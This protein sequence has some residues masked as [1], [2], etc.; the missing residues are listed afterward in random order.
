VQVEGAPVEWGRKVLD[1]SIG[2]ADDRACW[3]AVRTKLKEEDRADHNLRSWHVPTFAPKLKQ[4]RTSGYAS[5]CV[6]KPLFSRY[7]FAR[8]DITRQL[9]DINYTRGVQSV[10]SFGGSAVSIDDSVI[11]LLRAQVGA[12]GFVRMEDEFK[13]GDKVRVTSGPFQ[14]LGGIFMRKLN[15]ADRVKILLNAMQFQG[16]LLIDKQFL[17]KADVAGK[18]LPSN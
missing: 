4:R 18:S 10:V 6:S 9:H 5:R 16:H 8:F 17:Q 12:D 3:Y 7:I 13:P 15:G 11:D 1:M 14:S 2:E